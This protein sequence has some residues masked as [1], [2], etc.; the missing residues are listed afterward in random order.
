MDKE[1]VIQTVN[2]TQEDDRADYF[3]YHAIRLD[4][5]NMDSAQKELFFAE[6]FIAGGRWLSDLS[7]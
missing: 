3:Q 4:D 1:A 5:L 7:A 2:R 6:H